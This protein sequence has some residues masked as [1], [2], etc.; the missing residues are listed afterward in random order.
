MIT[1]YYTRANQPLQMIDPGHMEAYPNFFQLLEYV[2]ATQI[3]L[4]IMIDTTF[5]LPAR[6]EHDF[7]KPAIEV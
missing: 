3:P 5:G 1:D 2:K 4:S 7:Y 6:P